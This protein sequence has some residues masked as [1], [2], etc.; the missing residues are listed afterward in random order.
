[1]IK[2]VWDQTQNLP[3]RTMYSEP[4]KS[5][6]IIVSVWFAAQLTCWLLWGTQTQL[7]SLKYIHAADYLLETGS[8]P[9]KRYWFYSITV[10]LIALSKLLNAGYGF[11]FF[12][13]LLLSLAAHLVFFNSLRAQCR[14]NHFAP[15]ITTIF[16]C[17]VLPY[18]RWNFTLYTESLFYSLVLIF[19]SFCIRQKEYNIKTFLIQSLLLCLVIVSRPLGIL[20]LIP[21]I[22]YLFFQSPKKIKIVLAFI[23]IAGLL[24][25]IFIANIILTSISDWKVLK[26]FEEGSVICAMPLNKISIIQLNQKENPFLQLF[27]FI[28]LYPKEFLILSLKKTKAFFLMTRDYYST[29]HNLALVFLSFLFYIPLLFSLFREKLNVSILFSTLIILFFYAAIVLQCDDYH[30]RFILTLVPVFIYA[31]FFRFIQRVLK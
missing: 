1:L 2:R 14:E 31:G 22:L 26:P 5:F 30:N 20:I 18:Q 7:E 3:L 11:V 8:F 13:Q 4:K 29:G 19:F 9:E 6:L 21:W 17:L 24:F 28:K 23:S 10:F 12:I 25:M 27:Q 15:L 16:L